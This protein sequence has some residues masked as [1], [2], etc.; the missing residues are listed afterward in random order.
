MYVISFCKCMRVTKSY[1]WWRYSNQREA[2]KFED[3]VPKVYAQLTPGD[4]S[5]GGK[6]LYG[7]TT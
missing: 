2:Y 5:G 7:Q 6:T 1:A 4:C 3:N